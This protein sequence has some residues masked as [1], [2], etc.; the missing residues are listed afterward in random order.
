MIGLSLT[1]LSFPLCLSLTD[2]GT[3][4][5]A[6]VLDWIWYQEEFLLCF[7]ADLLLGRNEMFVW[8]NLAVADIG[9]QLDKSIGGKF[10]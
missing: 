9:D 8:S 3:Y 10:F 7:L 6:V 1:V 2:R 4:G 5:S